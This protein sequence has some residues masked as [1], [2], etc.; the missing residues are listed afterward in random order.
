MNINDQYY[1]YNK[2]KGGKKLYESK[3][4]HNAI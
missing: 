1:F 4:I 3:I 2:K